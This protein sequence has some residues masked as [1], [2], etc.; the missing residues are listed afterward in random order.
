MNETSETYP[1]KRS[2]NRMFWVAVVI[3]GVFIFT[4]TPVSQHVKTWILATTVFNSPPPEEING[5]PM[6]E[7]A[8]NFPL[9]TSGGETMTLAD[10]E[11][12]V[13]LI[14][15]W[16][17]WCATCRQ[18]NPTIQTL[19]QQLE[20]RDD[21]AFLLLS[22]DNVPSHAERYLEN[23]RLTIANAFPGGPMPSPLNSTT[24][25]TTYVIDKKGQI[26]YRNSGYAN[27]S[28]TTFQ[29]WIEEVANRG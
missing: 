4:F 5:P 24:V 23:S 6:S 7:A 10:Y 16:A 11:G 25:P 29:E 1:S 18:T 17:S 12:K 27:Y 21:V 3:L 15:Y 14:T 8:L 26:L 22:L 28:R 13:L 20:H 19:A 9:L 2:Q